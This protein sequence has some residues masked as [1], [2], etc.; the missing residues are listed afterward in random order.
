MQCIDYVINKYAQ[1]IILDV[2]GRSHRRSD[3]AYVD[4]CKTPVNDVGLQFCSY[5]KIYH[6]EACAYIFITITHLWK[7]Q[8]LEYLCT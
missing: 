5:K 3:D 2:L 1:L 8:K 4:A 7:R 6:P